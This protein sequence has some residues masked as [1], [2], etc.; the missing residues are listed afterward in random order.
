MDLED[1]APGKHAIQRLLYQAV[2]DFKGKHPKLSVLDSPTVNAYVRAVLEE[3]GR[4]GYEIETAGASYFAWSTLDELTKRRLT[5]VYW[6]TKAKAREAGGTCLTLFKWLNEWYQIRS[7]QHVARAQLYSGRFPQ[8]RNETLAHFVGRAE[9]CG[10]DAFGTDRTT[11]YIDDQRMVADLI[12]SNVT[13][14]EMRK[15]LNPILLE[16]PDKF[17]ICDHVN[18]AERTIH[19]EAGKVAPYYLAQAR[20]QAPGPQLAN[21]LLGPNQG[22]PHGCR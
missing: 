17:I 8:F 6:T 7:P 11:W 14:D 22:Q 12:K 10:Q 5:A 16:S 19:H 1:C 20:R 9:I 18:S 2:N 13:S 3:L 21:Q 4:L 15:F